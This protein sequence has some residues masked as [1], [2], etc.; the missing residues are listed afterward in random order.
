MAH[1]HTHT[2]WRGCVWVKVQI[3]IWPSWCHCHSL[4]LPQVN[5]DWFLVYLSD[6]GSPGWSRTKFKRA[7]KQ[8]CVC[9][10]AC[11]WWYTQWQF[12]YVSEPEKQFESR[13]YYCTQE[14]QLSLKDTYE[15]TVGQKGKRV[16]Y[17][18]GS[19]RTLH[20]D[21]STQVVPRGDP[22]FT[23]VYLRAVTRVIGFIQT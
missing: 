21:P 14:A 7:V 22:I 6:A 8:L 23:V 1:M 3:C 20:V 16:P 5:P 17:S 19:I 9:V 15:C 12:L 10:C 4:S 18:H 11:V 13:C 2:P